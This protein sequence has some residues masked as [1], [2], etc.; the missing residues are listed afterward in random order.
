MHL[1]FF[2]AVTPYVGKEKVLVRVENGSVRKCEADSHEWLLTPWP[3]KLHF[4]RGNQ[5]CN[6]K[7]RHNT[8]DTI[9]FEPL[10]K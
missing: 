1:E 10:E 6:S 4:C 7:E 8:G 2:A 5:E 9:R 3:Q